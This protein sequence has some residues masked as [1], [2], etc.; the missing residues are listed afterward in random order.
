[1]NDRELKN[2]SIH[3]QMPQLQRIPHLDRY[4]TASPAHSHQGQ[5]SSAA[6][7]FVSSVL[8]CSVQLPTALLPGR[9]FQ[10]KAEK[11]VISTGR[12]LDGEFF[13]FLLVQR[14]IPFN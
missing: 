9:G 8:V 10:S 4:N 5:S 1:M 11:W 14:P 12:V 13:F 7:G 6:L 2:C 3:G